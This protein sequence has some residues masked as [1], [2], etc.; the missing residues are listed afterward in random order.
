MCVSCTVF[1]ALHLKK[2]S[3]IS[4]EQTVPKKE[5]PVFPVQ[6][7][8]SSGPGRCQLSDQSSPLKKKKKVF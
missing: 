8:A 5:K 1:H 4:I 2:S 6:V 3:A 7:L